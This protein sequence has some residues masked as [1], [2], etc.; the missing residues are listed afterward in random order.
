MT[1]AVQAPVDAASGLPVVLPGSQS[2]VELSVSFQG[3]PVND[4]EVVVI[5]GKGQS[6]LPVLEP[7]WQLPLER[8]WQQSSFLSFLLNKVAHLLDNTTY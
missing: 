1:L 7:A 4:A 2:T 6:L 3:V 5:G 8:G